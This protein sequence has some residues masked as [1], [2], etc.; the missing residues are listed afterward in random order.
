[1]HRLFL[2]G[3]SRPALPRLALALALAL[4]TVLAAGCGGASGSSGSSGPSGSSGSR[5][6]IDVRTPAEFAEGHVEGARNLDLSAPG[7]DDEVA[8][9]PADA[10]Y[11][12]YC[13]SGN[14]SAEAARRMRAAGLDVTDGGGLD[15][16]RAAGF[17]FTG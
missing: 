7:F 5:V 6:V 3:L 1:M 9:L 12:V 17:P 16:M 14:R 10:A 15:D 11:L 8:A 2:Q 4:L 13:R